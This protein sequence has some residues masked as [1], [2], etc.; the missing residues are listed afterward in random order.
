MKNIQTKLRHNLRSRLRKTIHGRKHG[1]SPVRHLG[2]SVDELKKHL[3]SQWQEGMSWD[4]YGYYGWH[5]DHIIPLSTFD[6]TN[7]DDFKKA[8]HYSNL[9]PLWK[10]DNM[11][12]G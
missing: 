6:L 3:E 5:I 10:D 9:Q 12:K 2:C 7:P 11:K 1:L 8:C 4:N